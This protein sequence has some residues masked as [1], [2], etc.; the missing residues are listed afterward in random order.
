MATFQPYQRHTPQRAPRHYEGAMA[1]ERTKQMNRAQRFSEIMGAFQLYNAATGD[2]TPISDFLRNKF[3]GAEGAANAAGEG[4]Q[5]NWQ[6]MYDPDSYA[7]IP[8]G[9][10][11]D[12]GVTA[13]NYGQGANAA[14][15]SADTIGTVGTTAG[16]TYGGT[17]AAG[18]GSAAGGSAAGGS[19]AGGSAGGS[20][21]GAAGPYALIAAAVAANEYDARKGGYREGFGAEDY[22]LNKHAVEDMTKRTPELFGKKDWGQIV[23]GTGGNVIEKAAKVQDLEKTP[24]HLKGGLESAYR[25]TGNVLS[26]ALRKPFKGLF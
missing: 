1:D 22:L 11:A 5:L 2:K 20:A 6:G 12:Y 21:W 7:D 25:K 4:T 15:Q 3:G 9:N 10:G 18:G 23:G 19:A 26:D 24:Q 8:M 16:S 14:Q 17:A 13:T